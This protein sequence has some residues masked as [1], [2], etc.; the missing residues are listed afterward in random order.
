MDMY[1]WILRRKGFNVSNKGY[2]VYV[3]G[4]QKISEHG[5]LCGDKSKAKMTSSSAVDRI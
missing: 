2:F 5:M 4:D 1:V 3:N